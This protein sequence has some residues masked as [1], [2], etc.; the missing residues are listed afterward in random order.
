MELTFENNVLFLYLQFF[1]I[2]FIV[3]LV[4]SHNINSF[5]LRVIHL[6]PSLA[7]IAGNRKTIVSHVYRL[8]SPYGS[9]MG[10]L[11]VS[12]DVHV[13]IIGLKLVYKIV[14]GNYN[15]TNK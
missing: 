12:V 13:I 2:T 1:L 6:I 4:I 10:S 11:F 15:N 8:A 3:F 14:I 5:I 7:N 9:S